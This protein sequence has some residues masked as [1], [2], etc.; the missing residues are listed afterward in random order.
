[1]RPVAVVL[2][3]LAVS[4]L[5]APFATVDLVPAGSGAPALD[6]LKTK[7]KTATDTALVASLGRV[8]DAADHVRRCRQ[9]ADDRT[10]AARHAHHTI[11]RL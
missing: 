9:L 4:P 1:M 7:A 2:L 11:L 5:T 10:G 8:T 3:L 6:S